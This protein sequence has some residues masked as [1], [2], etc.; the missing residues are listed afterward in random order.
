[1]SSILI[2]DQPLP[3]LASDALREV[4]VVDL[5][6][7]HIGSRAQDLGQCFAELYMSCGGARDAAAM[8]TIAAIAEGYAPGDPTSSDRHVLREAIMHMGIHLA[9]F[10]WNIGKPR[11]KKVEE[12]VAYGN[13]LLV[14]AWQGMTEP[15]F[16][17]VWKEL[18]GHQSP[19]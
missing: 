7:C 19:S 17:N 10:P 1:M 3:D 18:F 2:R 12:T 8:K 11:N 9:V 14:S 5:E 4:F 16:A 13:K 6:F 15:E